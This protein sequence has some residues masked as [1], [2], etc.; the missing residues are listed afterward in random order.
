M[1]LSLDADAKK[2][3][4]RFD[5]LPLA[6]A[7]AG[8]YIS[9]TA[10]SFGDYLQMY[11]QSWT[12]LAENSDGLM[13]YDDRT[14]YS[15][16]NLSLKQVAA[17]DP[18]AAKIFRMMGYLRNADLW[19]E[20]F[21]EGVESAPGWF[22]NITRN[23]A[24][25]NKAMMTL[26]GYALIEAMP[27]HY[28]LHACVHEWVLEYL[29]GKF[30]VALSG[31]AMHCIA[32][33]VAWDSMPEYWLVNGRLNHHALRIERCYQREL[34]D[35]NAMD[36][37]D[38]Y[39]IGYLESMTGLLKEAEEMYVRALKGKEKAWG[40]EHTSTLNTVNNLG[41]LYK[42][43]GKM[44]EA[45]EM[46]LRALEGFKKIYGADHPRVLLVASNLSLLTNARN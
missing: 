37:G 27:G 32:Q 10:D 22:C 45:E 24:P 18:Q 19:Y 21:R 15:T 31:L 30:D 5:G 8:D 11:E 4:E 3:A 9:Q 42:D 34:V 17:Q 29:I 14:L 26:H 40:S 35:W 1:L 28:S 44:D 41:N 43:Q 7:T 2:L 23:K 36:P 39:N 13:E 12:D 46:Y 20:L 6:L 25:F 33:N 38:I 16:W